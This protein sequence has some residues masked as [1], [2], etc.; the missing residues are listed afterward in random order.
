MGKKQKHI[1]QYSGPGTIVKSLSPNGTSFSI[2]YKGRHYNRNVM[3]IN[4][5]RAADE[6][7]AALQLAIDYTV[8]VGSYIAVLD[9]SEDQHY[10]MAQVIDMTDQI[11][12][13]HY[14]GTKSRRLRDA[15]WIKLYHHP[16]TGDVVTEQL[17]NLIRHWTRFTGVIYRH[18]TN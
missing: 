14:M 8:C 18:Q 17:Q 7:P 11:T 9:G 1:L 10:H 12:T 3:H 16:G 6:V 13:L 2:L 15:K 4:K 5:Y